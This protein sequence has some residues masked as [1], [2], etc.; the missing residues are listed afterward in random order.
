MEP[1]ADIDCFKCTA[2]GKIYMTQKVVCSQC[3]EA[4]IVPAQVEGRGILV[5]STIVNYPPDN[6][7]DMAPYTSILVQIPDG[8]RFFAMMEGA[9]PD[10]P[11]GSNVKMV[12][13]DEVRGGMFFKLE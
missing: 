1:C 7:K 6:Y 4:N 13:V 8:P 2:C 9:V 11:P 5:D 3:G 12:A 10:I